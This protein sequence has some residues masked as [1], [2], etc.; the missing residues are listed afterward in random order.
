M[1]MEG[2]FEKELK[3]GSYYFIYSV[4]L[5]TLT[6]V[7][8]Q[9]QF[10]KRFFLSNNTFIVL[11]LILLIYCSFKCI[12]EKKN[13]KEITFIS[14]LIITFNMFLVHVMF[15]LIVFSH[16]D[17]FIIP[18]KE[19]EI[20]KVQDDVIKNRSNSLKEIIVFIKKRIIRKK[21]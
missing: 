1:E 19:L 13:L 10:L 17:F 20:V 9:V 21:Q 14:K 18:K 8:F 11:N 16:Q 2:K 12:Q 3:W 4:L 6:F 15:H 7:F 5:F